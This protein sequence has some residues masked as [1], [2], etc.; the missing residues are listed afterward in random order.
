[1]NTTTTPQ[2]P[3]PALSD[4]DPR[5]AVNIHR[6]QTLRIA[7]RDELGRLLP[8]SVLERAGRPEGPTITTLARAHTGKAIEVLAGIM[9]DPGAAAAARATAAQ[10][11]LDRGWGKA[12]VQIDMTTRANFFDFLR[13]IGVRA[14]A[15]QEAALDDQ[16]RIVDEEE[17]VDID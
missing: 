5:S 15:R 14:R 4:S 6:R 3:A 9:D 17:V 13:D 2:Q 1:M 11:L 8:G 7:E 16:G 10:A 12:P